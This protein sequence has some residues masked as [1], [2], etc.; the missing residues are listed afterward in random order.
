[1]NRHLGIALILFVA[2]L[3]M[4]AADL[5]KIDRSIG[6]E[7]H[8]QGKPYYC[9]L[10]SGQ[11]SKTRAW[12]VKDGDILYVSGKAD[13]EWLKTAKLTNTAHSY[14]VFVSE[15]DGKTTHDV[16]VNLAQGSLEYRHFDAPKL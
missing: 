2:H 11:E 4:H 1:M 10:V 13:G 16:K 6:K 3:P 14:Q 5:N 15:R 8:Y 7:P 9:L 12:L